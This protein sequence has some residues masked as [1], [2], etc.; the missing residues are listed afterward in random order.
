LPSWD[1]SKGCLYVTAPGTGTCRRTQTT[2][3]IT[4]SS[5]RE[6]RLSEE[7]T[8]HN[9]GHRSG[10]ESPHS[11]SQ[12]ALTRCCQTQLDR[13]KRVTPKGVSRCMLGAGWFA[14][15]CSKCCL[16]LCIIYPLSIYHSLL[17]I[18]CLSGSCTSLQAHSHRTPSI[19]RTTGT[20][21]VSR[22]G[23]IRDSAGAAPHSKSLN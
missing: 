12:Q 14:G 18:Y 8:K 11:T 2:Q 6:A 15:L 1:E 17:F 20:G 5:H 23:P 7:A 3:G 9:G 21:R 19:G 10:T 16:S 22:D 4:T 13:G